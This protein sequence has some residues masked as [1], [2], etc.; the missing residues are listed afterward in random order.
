M[1]VLLVVA[2]YLLGSVPTGLVLVRWLR[3]VD[4]RQYGSGAIHAANIYR[5]AGLYVGAAV[6]LADLLKGAVP[7]L[8]SQRLGLRP[9]WAVAAGIAAIVGHNWS[10]FLRLQGGKGTVTS[11]GVL[12]ALSPGAALLAA[13]VWLVTVAVTRL[14]SLASLL[15]ILSIP[16]AMWALRA[17]WASVAFGVVVALLGLYRHRADLRALLRGSGGAA[18]SRAWTDL[19]R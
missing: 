4:V 7:V 6:L 3:G 19:R 15:A 1:G 9:E 8:L 18:S 17:P 12:L 14:V 10:V 13:A 5:V 2:S 16:F 11:L